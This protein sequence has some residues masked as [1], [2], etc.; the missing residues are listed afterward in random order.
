MLKGRARGYRVLLQPPIIRRAARAPGPSC[1]D[2]FFDNFL[3][4][5]VRLAFASVHDRQFGQLSACHV[6]NYAG[7]STVFVRGLRTAL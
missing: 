1:A 5:G 3:D 2:L 6:S 4:D 7:T